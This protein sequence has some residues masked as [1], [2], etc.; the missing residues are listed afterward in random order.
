VTFY[1]GHIRQP[2][3]EQAGAIERLSADLGEYLDA[4]RRAGLEPGVVSGGS[5]PAAFAS[6]R[7]RGQTEMRPGTY[8]FNDRT[9]ALLDACTWDDCAYSVLATIISTAVPGQAVVDAGS[10]AI[11]RE[12]LRAGGASGYGALLDRPEI[13]VK[14][15]SEEH[16]LL[17][18]E[19]SDWRPRVGDRVRIVP[20]HVCISVNLHAGLWVVHGERVLGRYEVAARGWD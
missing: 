11:N 10:K 4:L 20:N 1:P 18:I 17:D 8:V 14:A 2:V 15:M 5:T 3:A 16:G 19:A 7:V 6:H 13:V 12:E 9:T